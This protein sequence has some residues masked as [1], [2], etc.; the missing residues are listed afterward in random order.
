MIRAALLNV[1]ATHDSL[2]VQQ[3]LYAMGEAAIDACAEISEIELTM[4]N[5]HRLL[6]SLQP[7]GLEN[8]NEI[9]VPTNE[10]F[11]LICGTISRGK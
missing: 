3:T 11:G 2:A 1:F 4:P 10:P 7:F 6:V 8:P 9:F 5:Q